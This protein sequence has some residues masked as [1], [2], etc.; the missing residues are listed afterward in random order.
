MVVKLILFDIDGTLIYTRGAGVKAFEKTFA[1]EFNLPNAIE[2]IT[3]AGR[4]DP[5]LVQEIFERHQLEATSERMRRFFEAYVF[6]LDYLLCKTGGGICAGIWNFIHGVK[7]LKCPPILGLLTGNIRLGAEIKLRHYQ[8]WDYFQTGAFGDDHSDRN[9]LAQIAQERASR[10][11]GHGLSGDEIL[12]IGDTPLD[13]A[14]A[15]AIGA[16]MLAVATGPYPVEQLRCNG[17][18]RTVANLSC[19]TVEEACA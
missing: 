5:S 12:V 17:K 16:R 7:K 19:L 1:T 6:W 9:V 13:I 3:F 18:G 10:L 11:A 2:N 14:C 4:T 8:L 15:E